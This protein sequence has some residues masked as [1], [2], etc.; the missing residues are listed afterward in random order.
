MAKANARSDLLK[1]IPRFPECRNYYLFLWMTVCGSSY[2][3]RWTAYADYIFWRIRS[4]YCSSL[5]QILRLALLCSAFLISSFMASDRTAS[6]LPLEYV[7]PQR[8]YD[9]FTERIS[10]NNIP[11]PLS[12]FN[13]L[14]HQ[15]VF[16]LLSLL[17]I[18]FCLNML[19]HARISFNCTLIPYHSLPSA[20]QLWLAGFH[21]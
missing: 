7:H 3:L 8:I 5:L 16:L 10:L 20:Q 14:T 12:L 9:H 11:H 2:D 13:W 17:F 21:I 18:Y 1:Q 15:V 6:A 4:F 19:P